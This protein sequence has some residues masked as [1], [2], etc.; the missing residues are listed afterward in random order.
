[1]RSNWEQVGGEVDLGTP[2][3]DV[4]TKVRRLVGEAPT[5]EG[6]GMKFMVAPQ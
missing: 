3:C 1:M 4:S 2:Y 6:G 5:G